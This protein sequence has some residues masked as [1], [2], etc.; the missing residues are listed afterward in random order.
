[1]PFL[2]AGLA[3]GPF[4]SFFEGFRRHL[5]SVEKVVGGL[6]VITGALFLTGNFTRL[7]FWFLETFPGARQ[8]RLASLRALNPRLRNCRAG[9]RCELRPGTPCVACHGG[10][11]WRKPPSSRAP[12]PGAPSV[13][14][15]VFDLHPAQ[16][17]LEA[18]VTSSF[19]EV[20]SLW[21][22][23]EANGIDS[24]GQSFDFSRTW[25]D[26][27]GIAEADRRFVVGLID[28]E[29]VAL[30]ALKRRRMI[31][32]SVLT[33]FAGKHV[34]CNAPL[35]DGKR[36]A[37][38]GAEGRRALWSCM[39][40]ALRGADLLY[41]P[42]MPASF[43]DLGDVFDAWGE[44]VEG[45]IVYRAQFTSWQ[46]CDATQRGKS[47][48]KHDRQQGDRLAALGQLEFEELR[49]GDQ[50]L[51]VLCTMFRQRSE[52]FRQMGV[53]DPFADP[54]IRA[55]YDATTQPQSGIDLRLHVLRLDGEIVAVRYNV[56]HG[57]R[58][59]CLISSMSD[60][61]AIQVGSPG[62]QCLLRVMQTVF[63]GGVTMFDMGAGFTDEKRHW[64]NVQMPLRHRY[65]P[66]TARGR[67]AGV[68]H[69]LFQSARRRI[70]TNESMLAF[71]K[72]LRLRTSQ[73]RSDRPRAACAALR[74]ASAPSARRGRCG[75]R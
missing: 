71:A 63:D 26:A 19:A 31:G 58:L 54:A 38:I 72:R 29:P 62:K 48:R 40:R 21:R 50:L 42:A 53:A 30:L 45:D 18:V 34:G 74:L 37:A 24:P 1:M 20:E 12:P 46:D 9:D 47:R 16:R 64:C 35:V 68:L 5:G 6:L 7:S 3:L 70:K 43:G 56:A 67:A 41:L 66:L 69:R 75:R 65:V 44:R 17:Q 23:L 4:L 33:W 25:A 22:T 15:Q 51:P 10:P 8:T 60:D 32:L 27:V 13:L 2:L 11:H 36:L 73:M 57:D 52:R 61:P 39:A 49:S 55:F 59:F 28:G 14:A